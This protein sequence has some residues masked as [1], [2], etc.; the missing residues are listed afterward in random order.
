MPPLPPVTVVVFI[1]GN[2]EIRPGE[3]FLVRVKETILHACQSHDWLDGR[4]RWVG[5]R[6]G[7]IKQGSLRIVQ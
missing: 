2:L 1:T 3:E 5:G 7:P 6:D 4:T